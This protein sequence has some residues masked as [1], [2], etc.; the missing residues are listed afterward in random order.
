M[1]HLW[2]WRCGDGDW[3][4]D[5]FQQKKWATAIIF[6]VGGNVCLGGASDL[7]ISRGFL[8]FGPSKKGNN[9]F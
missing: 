8:E 2:S 7:V 6:T 3:S 4:C 9:S 1:V 5:G